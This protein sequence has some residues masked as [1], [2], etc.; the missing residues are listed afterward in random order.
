LKI[1]IA[2]DMEGISGVTSWDHVNPAHA[3]YIRFRHMMTADV[4][5]A[6]CGAF[7][8]GAS[9][10]IIADGHWNSGNILVEEVD[11]RARLSSGTPSPFSMVNGIDASVS[12]VF[13]VGYHARAGTRNAIL[14]HTWSNKL[15]MNVWLNGALTGETGLNAAVCGHFGA[16]VMLVT[17]DQSVCAEARSLLGDL[18]TAVVKQASGR[19]AAECLPPSVSQHLIT[20]AAARAAQRVAAGEALPPYR[21]GLPVTLRVEFHSADMADRAMLLPGVQ[22]VDGRNIEFTSSDMPAAYWTF[23]AVMM[24]ARE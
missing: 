14:D 4:N 3:E 8:G 1:L 11:P 17:G 10:V 19:Y 6:V 24:A 2:V 5:A 16:P 7:D 15:V 9:E 22:R 21:P 20:E 12:A 23:R 13:L 18:E